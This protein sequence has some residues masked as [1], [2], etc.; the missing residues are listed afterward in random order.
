MPIFGIGLHIFVALFFAVHVVR[1]GR[2]L[3]WLLLLFCFPLLGS[4]V[5]FL[6]VFLPHSR[7]ERSL[8]K[9]GAAVREKL[10]P[11]RALREAQAAFDLTPTAHNQ[12]RLARALLDAGMAAQAVQQYDVCLSGP[13]AGDPDIRFAAA[14]ARLANGQPNDAV[15]A[16]LAL[17]TTH[18]NFSEEKVGLLLA[19]AYA[20]AGLHA[21][22][23][24]EFAAVV[25]RFASLEGRAEYALWA[26]SRREQALADAQLTQLN[27][28]RKH[29]SKQTRSQHAEMFKRLDAAVAQQ[30]R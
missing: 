29:M 16:L 25:G 21:E 14:E 5:Y 11:N 2:E 19:R 20:A 24:I 22:A 15:S 1:T 30:A 26:L 13:F 8:G 6:A 23:G 7:F 17:R 10:D 9:A 4:V 18:P 28:S 12:T 3:Y 27:H